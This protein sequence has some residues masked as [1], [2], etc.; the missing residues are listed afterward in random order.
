ML[1]HRLVTA[2]AEAKPFMSHADVFYVTVAGPGSRLPSDVYWQIPQTG[3][4]GVTRGEPR[5]AAAL[6]VFESG[7][8]FN[9]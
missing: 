8:N 7:L 9:I 4:C 2:V 5:V 3:G 1:R 6:S